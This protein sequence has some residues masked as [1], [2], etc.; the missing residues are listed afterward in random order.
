MN[1]HKTEIKK[2]CKKC[3][4]LEGSPV[5]EFCLSDACNCHAEEKPQE[6]CGMHIIAGY[7]WCAEKYPCKMHGKWKD[8]KTTMTTTTTPAEE[9]PQ[10]G[11]WKDRLRNT[12]RPNEIVPHWNKNDEVEYPEL[13]K[14]IE[15]E[16]Q[17]SQ[18]EALKKVERIITE[19]K[20][21]YHDDLNCYCQE[22]LLQI[23][24]N[25]NPKE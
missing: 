4:G 9:K 25:F 1:T 12:F 11:G 14:F 6:E 17:S 22:D 18:R 24:T 15:V 16:I 19:Y 10:E 2:C 13:E 7:S 3:R 20:R 5:T 23:L 21:H 8:I